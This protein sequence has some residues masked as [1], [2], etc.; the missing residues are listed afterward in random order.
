MLVPY[1]GRPCTSYSVQAT[2]QQQLRSEQSVQARWQPNGSSPHRTPP[3]SSNSRNSHRHYKSQ[4][5][6]ERHEQ[7]ACDVDPS[8]EDV[9]GGD[10][11]QQHQ[12]VGGGAADAATATLRPTSLDSRDGEVQAEQYDSLGYEQQ[13][14][15]L[16]QMLTPDKVA[17]IRAISTPEE[18]LQ[19]DLVLQDMHMLEQMESSA[20]AQ[21]CSDLQ[22]PTTPAMLTPAP[23]RR[24]TRHTNVATRLAQEQRQR[25]SAEVSQP[26]ISAE[27]YRCA[28]A[29]VPWMHG[30]LRDAICRTFS[31]V[32][33]KVLRWRRTKAHVSLIF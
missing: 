8:E 33:G 2:G 5:Q 27:F 31:A 3:S 21:A 28:H 9:G 19:L 16:R 15:V 26:C 1:V 4:N 30:D 11:Q 12:A 18:Q 17:Q 25:Y 32:E 22:A 14:V 13:L 20:G 6:L 10:G 7:I 29:E 23:R 24:S